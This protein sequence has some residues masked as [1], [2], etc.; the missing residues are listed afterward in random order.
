[1][2]QNTCGCSCGSGCGVKPT[3]TK[4]KKNLTITWQRLISEGN[5]CPRCGSTEDELNKAV[6][7]LKEKLSPLGIGVTL[8]KN[9]LSLEEFKKDPQKSN[10]ILLNGQ[11]LEDVIG[12]KTGQ[13]QCCDVCGDEQCRTVDTKGQSFETVPVELV[14][15]AGLRVISEK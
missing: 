7:L 5:T 8:E 11:L 10:R 3:D 15:E 13:S 2:N 1:M 14:V 4:S 9:E 6:L 12:A